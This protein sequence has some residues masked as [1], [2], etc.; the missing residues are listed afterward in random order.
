MY[1][2]EEIPEISIVLF[3]E[4]KRW[5]NTFLPKTL[6]MFTVFDSVLEVVT[7]RLFPFTGLGYTP[8]PAIV[9]DATP[10]DMLAKEVPNI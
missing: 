4:E 3:I 2:P 10:K 7:V 1:T 6:N 8:N 5:L 9:L